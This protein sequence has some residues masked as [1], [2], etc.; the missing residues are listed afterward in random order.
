MKNLLV[1]PKSLLTQ[2]NECNKGE[3]VVRSPRLPKRC[4]AGTDAVIDL[5]S[6]VVLN[7]DFFALPVHAAYFLWRQTF[8]TT[9]R[10]YA[11]VLCS[12]GSGT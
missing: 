11:G 3:L 6:Q 8:E 1:S 2:R 7:L 12:K 4:Q 9:M 5:L 10:Y